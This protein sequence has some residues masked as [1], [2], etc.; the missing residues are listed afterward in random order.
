M[1]N[2]LKEYVKLLPTAIE[3]IDSVAEGLW[4]KLNHDSL[5]DPQKEEIV[6][7]KLIC[8][9]CPYNS[10]NA[11]DLFNYISYRTDDHCIHCSC[12]ID[13]KTE[14]LS[15]NCGIEVYNQNNPTKKLSLN[16]EAYK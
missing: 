12:N 14:C 3:N 1:L 5:T 6:K 7:R 11:S 4:N 16:W 13:L 8:L 2:A 10:K 15:C 9:E